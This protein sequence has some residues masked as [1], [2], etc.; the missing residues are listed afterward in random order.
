MTTYE[1]AQDNPGLLPYRV[2][3]LESFRRDTDEWRRAVD[4]DRNDLRYMRKEVKELTAA[5]DD[6]KKILV[7]TS[8]TIAGSAVMV[9]VSVL[10]STGKIG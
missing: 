7:R 5:V 4:D 9:L 10:L 8:V 2:R 1:D 6:L 3:Q